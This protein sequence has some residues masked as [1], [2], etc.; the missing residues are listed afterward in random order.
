MLDR[1][2]L[3]FCGEAAPETAPSQK[4]HAKGLDALRAACQ[5]FIRDTLLPELELQVRAA[6][7]AAGRWRLEMDPFPRTPAR[8]ASWPPISAML[9]RKNPAR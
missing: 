8:T 6:S 2:I 1:T 3:G 9:P 7:V 4:Q 5:T